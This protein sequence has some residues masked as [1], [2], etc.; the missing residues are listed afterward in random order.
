MLGWMVEEKAIAPHI[1]VFDKTERTD[2]TFQRDDFQWNEEHDEY[3][4]PAGNTL[5]PEWRPFKN[6]RTHITKADSR[7]GCWA[8]VCAV[9]R[10]RR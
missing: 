1:P 3:R 9:G 4:C 6:P 7:T 8:R 5:R 2:G 10:W